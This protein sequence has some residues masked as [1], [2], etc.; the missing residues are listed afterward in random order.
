MTGGPKTTIWEST[1]SGESLRRMI[2]GLPFGTPAIGATIRDPNLG[3]L[4]CVG[5]STCGAAGEVTEVRFR[6]SNPA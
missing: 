2:L 5:K 4:V 1:P 6:V 3:E